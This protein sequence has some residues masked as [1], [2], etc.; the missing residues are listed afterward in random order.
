MYWPLTLCPLHPRTPYC[1]VCWPVGGEEGVLLTWMPLIWAPIKEAFQG[2]TADE[3]KTCLCCHWATVGGMSSEWK[4]FACHVS[5]EFHW[6]L[7]WAKAHRVGR[8][9]KGVRMTTWLSLSFRPAV[10]ATLT[11][12]FTAIYYCNVWG[13]LIW[14]SENCC[15][16]RRPL[17][18]HC[19]VSF[20]VWNVA[21]WISVF[22]AILGSKALWMSYHWVEGWGEHRGCSEPEGKIQS[23]G[24]CTEAS[25]RGNPDSLKR[26]Q[27][28]SVRKYQQH[29]GD[30]WKTVLEIQSNSLP[31]STQHFFICAFLFLK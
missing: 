26:R 6:Q 13:L 2:S 5:S 21:L 28:K 27:R 7:S 29:L 20:A 15:T 10:W 24:L 1:R 14:V 19:L 12:L 11:L 8:A 25:S 16:Q 30:I 3:R 31:W 22:I 23:L 4:P 18:K 17:D 9:N